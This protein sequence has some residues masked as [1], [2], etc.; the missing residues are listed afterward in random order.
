MPPGAAAR[1]APHLGADDRDRVA[2]LLA[3]I[4][5]WRRDGGLAGEDVAAAEAA[6]RAAV[7][8]LLAPPPPPSP[9]SSAADGDAA[10]P[11]LDAASEIGFDALCLGLALAHLSEGWVGREG[12]GGMGWT[13][14][15]PPLFPPYFRESDRDWSCSSHCIHSYDS[16]RSLFHEHQAA[17]F[18]RAGD[19]YIAIWTRR[20][21]YVEAVARSTAWPAAFL[22]RE[23]PPFPPS[24]LRLRRCEAAAARLAVG[25]AARGSAREMLTGL[26][27]AAADAVDAADSAEEEGEGASGRAL[28]P[29]ALFRAMATCFGRITRGAPLHTVPPPSPPCPLPSF[30]RWEVGGPFTSPLPALDS[31][32]VPSPLPSPPLPLLERRPEAGQRG[33]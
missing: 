21:P 12:G 6:M 15:P 33:A 22:L 2:A 17:S 29:S 30:S 7:D 16:W 4:A 5:P 1:S 24:A 18:L 10:P 9:D 28:L 20:P 27:A 32:A 19:S 26:L 31:T 11:P 3:L 25:L 23:P 13:S 8:T 14:D